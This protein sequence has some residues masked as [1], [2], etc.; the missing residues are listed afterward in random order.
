MVLH[1]FIGYLKDKASE[2]IWKPRCTATAAWEQSIGITPKAKASKY[3][4]P[5]GDWSDGYGL[6]TQSGFCPCGASLDAHEDEH[7]PGSSSDPTA[8]DVRL[9]E[10]LL[11]GKEAV[12]IDGEDGEDPLHSG[13]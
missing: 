4:G 8:A 3:K 12:I 2:L 1:R 7:C 10:S 13:L 5:W 9:L 6:I 11:A